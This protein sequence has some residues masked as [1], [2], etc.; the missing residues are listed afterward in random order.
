MGLNQVS[1][2]EAS[3]VDQGVWVF[4]PPQKVQEEGAGWGKDDLV[5]HHLLTILIGQGN[6]SEL[7]LQ[8]K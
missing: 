4:V 5:S 1:F 7:Q 3:H 8:L 2:R 6:T